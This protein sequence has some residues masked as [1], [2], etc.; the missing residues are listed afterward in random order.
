MVLKCVAW[1]IPPLA[2]DQ[3]AEGEVIPPFPASCTVGTAGDLCGGACNFKKVR[4]V[5]RQF[6]CTKGFLFLVWPCGTQFSACWLSDS[7]GSIAPQS[8]HFTM[9][10]SSESLE[11]KAFT[12]SSQHAMLMIFARRGGRSLQI[13]QSHRSLA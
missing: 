3:V 10:S 12:G 5:C 4:G 2:M 6:A 13:S 8:L 7:A 11:K 1:C 9:D